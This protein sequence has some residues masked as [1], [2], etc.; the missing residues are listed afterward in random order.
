LKVIDLDSTY[1]EWL[2][3]NYALGFDEDLNEKFIG[4]THDESI[5]FAEILQTA[6]QPLDSRTLDELK[7]FIEL[8]ERHARTLAF[9]RKARSLGFST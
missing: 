1:R 4:L 9:Q 7:R 8:Q 6:L 3:F 2:N 5:F